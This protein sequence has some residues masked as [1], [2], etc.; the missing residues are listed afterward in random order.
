MSLSQGSNLQTQYVSEAQYCW[1]RNPWPVGSHWYWWQTNS[2]IQDSCL[3]FGAF[4]RSSERQRP[5]CWQ[6]Q[7][8]PDAHPNTFCLSLAPFCSFPSPSSFSTSTFIT[9]VFPD[10][11]CKHLNQMCL[12]VSSSFTHQTF[13]VSFPSLPTLR[14]PSRFRIDFSFYLASFFS[15]VSGA[16]SPPKP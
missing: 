11:L 7:V 9:C 10:S 6:S 16:L 13:P 12:P 4:E 8:I 14:S 2:E 3:P 15:L 5:Y 1:G